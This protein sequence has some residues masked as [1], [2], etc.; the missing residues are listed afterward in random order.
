M[1]FAGGA[2]D[3][4]CVEFSLQAPMMGPVPVLGLCQTDDQA[5]QRSS[6]SDQA[7]TMRLA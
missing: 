1:G 4:L 3:D 7:P 5:G 2:A 6:R